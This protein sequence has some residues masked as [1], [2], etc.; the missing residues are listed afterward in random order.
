VEDPRRNYEFLK[1]VALGEGVTLFGVADV[2]ALRETFHAD[3]QPVA[4]DLLYGIALGKRLSNAVMDALVDGPTQLYLSHYRQVNW[5]LDR[6]AL[7]LADLIEARGFRAVP[8]PASQLVDWESLRGH[9]CHRTVAYYAGHGWFGR[10]NLI[11]NPRY[12]ARVRYATVLTNFPLA[13]D[14][15]STQDCGDC[16]ACVSVCPAGAIQTSARDFVRAACAEQTQAFSKARHLGQ[17]ICG[18]CIRA[19]PGSQEG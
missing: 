14:E 8:I 16:W 15:P 12:G 13:A 4:A 9:V 7:R 18:L 11:V 17:R 19:C 1:E 6:V 2:R 5:L 10:N 3:L